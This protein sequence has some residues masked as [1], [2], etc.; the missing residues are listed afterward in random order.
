MSMTKRTVEQTREIDI[1]V[2]R[3]AGYLAQ[4]KKGSRFWSLDGEFTGIT[5]VAWDGER[6]TID[7]QVIDLDK[8]PCPFGGQRWWFRCGCG[9][10]VMKLYS[11]NNN[12]WACRHCYEL[13]YATRQAIPRHRLI[14]RAQYIRQSL[15]GTAN[16]LEDFPP[17]PTGMHQKRYSR[18]R[19]EYDR[20]TRKAL[21]MCAAW[22]DKITAR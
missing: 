12:P 4:P 5:S 17:R 22:V 14:L 20:L 11:P 15:G 19:A 7:H 6:L 3:R 1:G 18:M 9:R 16:I 2:L 10:T 8:T 21:G 13:T